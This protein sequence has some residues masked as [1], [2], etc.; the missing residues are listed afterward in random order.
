VDAGTSAFSAFQLNALA[1]MLAAS[2]GE[3][4]LTIWVRLRR[5]SPDDRYRCD[6]VLNPSAVR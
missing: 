1:I 6:L 2:L 5:Q 3:F 4:L